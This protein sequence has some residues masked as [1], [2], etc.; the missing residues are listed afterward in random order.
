[1]RVSWAIGNREPWDKN[2]RAFDRCAKEPKF[3]RTSDDHGAQKK[4]FLKS[5]KHILS[6]LNHLHRLYLVDWPK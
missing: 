2:L 3:N 6:L 5:L 4:L 1:M